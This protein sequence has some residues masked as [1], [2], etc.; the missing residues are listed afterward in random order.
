MEMAFGI[1]RDSSKMFHI[2]E[3]SGLI[4]GFNHNT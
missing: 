2:A 3:T 4:I 1:R